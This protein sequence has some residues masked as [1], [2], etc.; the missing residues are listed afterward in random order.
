MQSN[1]AEIPNVRTKGGERQSSAF[2]LCMF[3]GGYSIPAFLPWLLADKRTTTP[4]AMMDQSHSKWNFWYLPPL[5]LP[6]TQSSYSLERWEPTGPSCSVSDKL[7]FL[8]GDKWRSRAQLVRVHGEQPLWGQRA[9]QGSC[10]RKMK[11]DW[12]QLL[13]VPQHRWR[14]GVIREE[15][16]C[17]LKHGN[18]HFHLLPDIVK[19]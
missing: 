5:L 7:G 17:T 2:I 19:E 6:F 10:A 11:R 3:L 14:W 4:P 18:D 16:S 12:A 9:C 13:V 8:V 15:Q 1:I